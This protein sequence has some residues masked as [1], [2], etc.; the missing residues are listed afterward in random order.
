MW[1]RRFYA[2]LCNEILQHTSLPHGVHPGFMDADMQTGVEWDQRLARELATCRVFVPLYSRRYFHSVQCGKEWAA[3]ELR[4]RAYMN[5]RNDLLDVIVPA[6]W[7]PV[8]EYEIPDIA[9]PIQYA[10]PSMG[11]HYVEHGLYTMMKIRRFRDHYK[12]AVYHLARR[13]IEVAERVRL[14]PGSP[15]DYSSI[16]SAFTRDP[17]RRFQITI[18]AG[19][20]HE[21]PQGRAADYYGSTARDW[22]P[23]HPRSSR[24]IAE[25]AA[26]IISELDFEPEIGSGL[27][28]RRELVDNRAPTCPG[29]VLL[30]PWTLLDPRYEELLRG[31][32]RAN[33]PW[34]GVIV[35]WSRDD[36]QIAEH[37]P[38]LLKRLRDLLSSKVSQGRPSVRK[39]VYG[40]PTIEEFE[41]NLRPLLQTLANTYLRNVQAVP[42]QGSGHGLPRLWRP[43]DPP[44]RERPT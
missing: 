38:V 24:P 36:P 4:R 33:N 13:I 29:L 14:P 19:A 26:E 30:D 42:P 28:H 6:Y 23:Y 1:A 16:K 37:T 15:V 3:F 7:S 20:A 39:A 27:D 34:I 41:L 10:D 5:G 22:N 8:P 32:N 2:E 31:L 25:V 18:I 43:D 9:K 40:V 17:E 11:P 21:L 12:M 44:E 35:P